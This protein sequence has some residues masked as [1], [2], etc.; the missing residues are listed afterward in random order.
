M[1][2]ELKIDHNKGVVAIIPTISISQ[3]KVKNLIGELSS[4]KVDSILIENS[5]P[6]FSFSNSMNIGIKEALKQKEVKY[7][8][9]S[10]DDV[11]E[12]V[13]LD[14]M[15]SYLEHNPVDYAHPYVNNKSP[16]IIFTG[17]TIRAMLN[18]G[19]RSRAPFYAK[20]LIDGI[21][22]QMPCK[23]FLIFAPAIRKSSKIVHVQPFGLFKKK[24]LE[25][26]NFDENLVNGVEDLDLAFRLWKSGYTGT[27][28]SNWRIKH[29]TSS[30]FKLLNKKTRLGSY[31]G[32]NS[33]IIS[34]WVYFV[35]KNLN[36]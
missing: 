5:G 21:K 24:V 8:I 15:I 28:R 3:S 6:S 36:C 17:I 19:L 14:N 11:S 34:N 10:N 4:Y 33:H 27:T 25:D 22:E 12:I 31:Y 1:K 20:S 13:G 16:S 35:K 18:W 30:S 9:L 29:D 2:V 32:D 23:R 26:H 7:I